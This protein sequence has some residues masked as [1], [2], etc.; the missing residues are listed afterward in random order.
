MPPK[1]QFEDLSYLLTTPPES[2]T[3]STPKTTAT[4]HGPIDIPTTS[5]N[6]TGCG[7]GS[8]GIR[9]AVASTMN[10]GEGND[11]L[12]RKSKNA[13][14]A[15]AKARSLAQSQPNDWTIQTSKIRSTDDQGMQTNETIPHNA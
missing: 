2:W 12:R 5:T 11:R 3:V 8:N 1:R 4:Q 6:V 9:R 7:R 15:K 10:T 13:Y 14:R